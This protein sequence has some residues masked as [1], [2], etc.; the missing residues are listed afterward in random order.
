VHTPSAAT[1][2]CKRRRQRVFGVTCHLLHLAHHALKLSLPRR[3]MQTNPVFWCASRSFSHHFWVSAGSEETIPQELGSLTRAELGSITAPTSS[4]AVTCAL[5]AH[6][7]EN[8]HKHLDSAHPPRHP[9]LVA[10]GAKWVA[11]RAGFSGNL[12]AIWN[13]FHIVFAEEYVPR[14]ERGTA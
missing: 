6:L 12:R 4:R 8:L 1:L 9:G 7:C 13:R 3:A 11:G 2:Q 10:M 14:E 5:H